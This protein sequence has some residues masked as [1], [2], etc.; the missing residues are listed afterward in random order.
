MTSQHTHA[1]SL[2]CVPDVAGPVVISSEEK[3]SRNGEG[4]R[5]NTA[6][7]VIV[8]E[9]VEFSVSTD[10]KQPARGIVGAGSECVAVGEES[11]ECLISGK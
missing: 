5:G 2:E 4:D 3:P 9:R 11:K 6:Q 8:S 7:D 1:L 10:I